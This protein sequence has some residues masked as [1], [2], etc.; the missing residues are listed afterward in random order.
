M[1]NHSND[2]SAIA[3]QFNTLRNI[4]S[5]LDILRGRKTLIG[6][7]P[8]TELLKLKD[9]SSDKVDKSANVRDYTNK[10]K[11]KEVSTRS[12]VPQKIFDS[13]E[14]EPEKFHILNGG[15]TILCK[16]SQENPQKENEL[17]LVNPSIANGGHTADV[18][19]KFLKTNPNSDAL[20]KIEVIYLDGSKEEN[21]EFELEVSI[22]RNS[23]TA[24]KEISIMGK[25]GIFNDINYYNENTLATSETDVDSYPTDKLLQC[26]FLLCPDEAWERWE[27]KVPSRPGFH[28]G[29]T[30]HFKRYRKMHE[31]RTGSAKD[32]W[33]Y[34]NKLSPIALKLYLMFQE[35]NLFNGA[36]KSKILEENS[37]T[38]LKNGKKRIKWG[39]IAPI[40]SSL[41]FFV[42][43]KTGE[44]NMP[45][46]DTIR[47]IIA[48][49]YRAGYEHSKDPQTLGK[50]VQ[51]YR[52]PLKDLRDLKELI[53]DSKDLFSSSVY[54]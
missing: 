34:V 35:T 31:N 48:S 32:Q 5:K 41:S 49:V 11:G 15:I 37:Y 52:Q 40:I 43:P 25:Q 22:A 14:N 1:T 3:I 24:V 53:E 4:S 30:I 51:A 28:S 26:T 17:S 54:N 20:V 45:D 29:K 21:D 27:N 46:D 50:T 6:L 16:R 36:H 18:I 39:W 7:A 47:G 2:G 23:Q 8:I 42:D 33:N 13:L 44:F 10:S 12:G 38:S 9:N 19:L